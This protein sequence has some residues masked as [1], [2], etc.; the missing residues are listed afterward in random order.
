MI[1]YNI[2]NK[3]M[4]NL[5][6]SIVILSLQDFDLICYYKINNFFKA[7]SSLRASKKRNTMNF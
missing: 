4:N 5:F 3:R 1:N 6:I 7:S 2:Y